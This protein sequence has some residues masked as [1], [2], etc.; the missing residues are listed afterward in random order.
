MHGASIASKVGNSMAQISVPSEHAE[1]AAGA[2]FA[3]LA[4]TSLAATTF[5]L[6][7]I[8]AGFFSASATAIIGLILFVGGIVQ[9]VVGLWE[10][11]SGS[12]VHATT[13]AANGVFWVTYGGV[14]VLNLLLPALSPKLL[15]SASSGHELGYFFLAWTVLAGIVS[16]T[17]LRASFAHIATFF[18]FFL[19]LLAL[20][21]GAF[22]G[23]GSVLTT[24]GGWIGII[25][26]IVG[27]YTALASMGAPV[28]LP[29]GERS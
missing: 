27:G 10:H 15:A 23:G 13:F 17:T 8:Q 24:I 22:I 11:R 18:L 7:A 6:G 2:H 26:G 5:F 29:T 4:V 12:A 28:A 16:L 21:I 20:T 9:L 1:S 3:P 19:T 14:I 25:T